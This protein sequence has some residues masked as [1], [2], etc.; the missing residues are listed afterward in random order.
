MEKLYPNEVSPD[1]DP[2]IGQSV[3][4]GEFIKIILSPQNDGEQ[5]AGNKMQQF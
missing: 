4:F 1:Q 3:F 5:N 2:I